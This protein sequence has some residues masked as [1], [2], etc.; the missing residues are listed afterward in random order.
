[1]FLSHNDILLL[2]VNFISIA[3]GIKSINIALERIPLFA[4]AAANET[5]IQIYASIFF[6]KLDPTKTCM[7][8]LISIVIS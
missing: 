2:A 6:C 4:G 3:V 7:I 8:F 5:A 1:V